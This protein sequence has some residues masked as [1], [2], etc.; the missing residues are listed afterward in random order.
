MTQSTATI[1]NASTVEQLLAWIGIAETRAIVLDLCAQAPASVAALK[2]ALDQQDVL[3]LKQTAHRIKGAY[4]T[5]G[6]DALCR[7]LQDLEQDPRAWSDNVQRQAQTLA[8]IEASGAQLLE[9]I[10]RN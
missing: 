6:C 4:A 2:A 1:L 3:A 9:F 8:L 10:N 7:S 5:L